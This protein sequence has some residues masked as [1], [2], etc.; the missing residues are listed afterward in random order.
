MQA[1]DYRISFAAA[2]SYS[3]SVQMG[4]SVQVHLKSHVS[5]IDLVVVVAS[6]SVHT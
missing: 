4:R 5:M 2:D 6:N 1:G 3:M